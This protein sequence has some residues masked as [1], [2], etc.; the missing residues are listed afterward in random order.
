[1]TIRSLKPKRMLNRSFGG[2]LALDVVLLLF[3]A[4]KVLPME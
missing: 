1:M 4:V 2:N 3:G